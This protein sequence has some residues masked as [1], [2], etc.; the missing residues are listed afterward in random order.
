MHGL[1]G[2]IIR[3]GRRAGRRAGLQPGGEAAAGR[4]ARAAPN[5][6]FGGGARAYGKALGGLQPDRSGHARRRRRPRSTR[7]ASP[8]VVLI[9]TKDGLGSGVLVGADGRI[10]T[11]LHVVGDHTEVGVVFKPPMEG[12]AIAKADLR[13]PRCCAATRWPTWR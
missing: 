1:V 2:G 13:P 9:V 8:S 3:K 5:E 7:R 12:A 6:R 10:V 11:N 4:R